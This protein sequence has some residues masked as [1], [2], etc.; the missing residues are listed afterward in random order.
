MAKADVGPTEKRAAC[1]NHMA[2]SPCKPGGQ[3]WLFS[4]CK[5]HWWSALQA[6]KSKDGQAVPLPSAFLLVPSLPEGM[7]DTE[8]WND[9]DRPRSMFPQIVDHSTMVPSAA[10]SQDRHGTWSSAVLG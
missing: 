2:A 7:A 6:S 8:C 10:L 5:V 3:W 4:L 1:C 9:K